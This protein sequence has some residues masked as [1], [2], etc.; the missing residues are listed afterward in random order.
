MAKITIAGDAVVITSDVTLEDLKKVSKYNPKALVLRDENDTLIYSIAVSSNAEAG[1]INKN[2]AVFTSVAPD[3]SGL[4]TITMCS[5]TLSGDIKEAVADKIGS[6]I[7]HLSQ[8]EERLPQVLSQID[9]DKA[10][11]MDK[12]TVA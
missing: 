3:G 12:I 4:A 2:G 5:S 9:A 1:E 11:V 7:L 8:I 6:A 10:A